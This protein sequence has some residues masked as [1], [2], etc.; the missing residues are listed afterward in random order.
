MR[1]DLFILLIFIFLGFMSCEKTTVTNQATADVFIKSILY[2]GDTLHGAAHSV[3]SYNGI[4]E[5][6][7]KT[8]QGDTLLL[9]SES[10]QGISVYLDPSIDGG[11][12]SVLPPSPG[13]YTYRVIFKDGTKTTL[14]NILGG[15]YLVPAKIDSIARSA[16]GQFVIL[17]W[18]PVKDAQG[19]QI[20]ITKGNTEVVAAKSYFQLDKL[21]IEYP[22]SS[23]SPYLP[24]TFT[25][26]LDALLFESSAHQ[27][28]QAMSVAT[29]SADLQ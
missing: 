20:R 4:K 27:S 15:N 25:V 26:E 22:I 17:K 2:Q 3:F 14:T 19:Y 23:F 28:L 29:G 1:I 12:Y 6:S 10:D 5:V 24:G 11:N 16:D 9:P 18:E 7:V 21:R 8:P 13:T